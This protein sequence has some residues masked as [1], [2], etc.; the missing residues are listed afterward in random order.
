MTK[1]FDR[2]GHPQA[3]QLLQKVKQFHLE[4]PVPF[5]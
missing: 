4:E 2:R 3:N 1:R 5:D